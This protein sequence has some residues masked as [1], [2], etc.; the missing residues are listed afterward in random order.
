MI[1]LVSGNIYLVNVTIKVTLLEVGDA[2]AEQST[3]THTHT[4]STHTQ[5]THTQSTHTHTQSTHTQSTHTKHTYIKH[6]K[7]TQAHA[8]TH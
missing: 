4:Q 7:H 2:V 1:A 6:T 8:H 3:H 5:S